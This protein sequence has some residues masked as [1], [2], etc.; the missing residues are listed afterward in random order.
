[1]EGHEAGEGFLQVAVE[2]GLLSEDAAA[3]CRRIASVLAEI[4]EGKPIDEIAVQKGYLTRKQADTVR[5]AAESGRIGAYQVLERLGAGAVGAVFR[6]RDT[7]NGTIVALKVLTEAARQHGGDAGYQR[8]LRE[9]RIATTL[10][11]PN[12]TRGFE[13][14]EIA[15]YTYLA[16]EFVPGETLEAQL[17]RVGR[18]PEKVAFQVALDVLRALEHLQQFQLIHRDVKPGNVMIPPEGAAKLCDLGLTRP[19]L[20]EAKELGVVEVPLG[21]AVYVSPEQI[22]RPDH[23]DWRAD[24]YSLGAT[25]YHAL[26]GTPPFTADSPAAVAKKHLTTPPRDPRE[27][28]LELSEGGVNVVLKMLQKDPRDRH[29]S[30]ADLADDMES[31][32]A[33]KVPVH[34]LTTAPI[35]AKVPKRTHPAHATRPRKSSAVPLVVTGVAVL[36]AGGAAWWSLAGKDTKPP[37]EPHGTAP[38]EPAPAPAGGATD[39][40]P[41]PPTPAAGRTEDDE[42]A[43]AAL[44]SALTYGAEHPDEWD[45]AR[46]RF[47][48]VAERYA[49]TASGEQAKAKIA[50]LE[51]RRGAAGD[52]EFERR[53]SRAASA[54]S[55]GQLTVAWTTYDDFPEALA[56]TAG[57]RRAAEEQTRLAAAARKRIDDA[58]GAARTAAGAGRFADAKKALDD[59]SPAALGALA[60]ELATAR[61][62]LVSEEKNAAWQRDAQRRHFGATFAEALYLAGR[63]DGA[64]AR[65]LL[66]ARRPELSLHEAELDALANDL[67]E[68]S[69]VEAAA[70]ESW[71][72]MG[73]APVQLTTAGP[74]AAKV[75]GKAAGFADT[76]LVVETGPARRVQLELRDVTAGDVIDLAMRTL[77]PRRP[78]DARA[79]LLY[80]FARTDPD[81]AAAQAESLRAAGDAAAADEGAARIEDLRTFMAEHATLLVRA[82]ETA[83]QA[84]RIDEARAKFDEAVRLAPRDAKAQFAAGTA[85]VAAGDDDR[86]QAAFE[87]AVA[88]EEAPVEAH[89]RLAQ[90]LARRNEDAAAQAEFRKFLSLADR[91]DPLRAEADGGMADVTAKLARVGAEAARKDGA[92][93]FQAKRW[94]EAEAAYARLVEFDPTDA[95]GQL[96]LGQAA[97]RQEKAFLAYRWL[98]AFLRDHA[99]DKRAGEAHKELAGLERWKG[100]RAEDREALDRARIA[101][102]EGRVDE[103]VELYRGA[104]RGSPFL[105]PARLGLARALAARAVRTGSREDHAAAVQAADDLLVLRADSLDALSVRAAS[106]LVLGD[107]ARAL[108]DAETVLKADAANVAMA[109]VAGRA[110]LA[111]D[112]LDDATQWFD[113]AFARKPS[114]EA[115]LGR[116]LVLERRRRYEHAMEALDEALESH[117]PSAALRQEIEDARRRIRPHLE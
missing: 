93:H 50:D 40:E 112:R 13:A 64:G 89:L 18:L 52:A 2:Q 30:L 23:I 113:D 59:A 33:G 26:T 107:P 43:R 37:E 5:R 55:L 88:L 72:K 97:A 117:V 105:Q 104:A 99:D 92:K 81:R 1:M 82:G 79:A 87:R 36:A 69:R 56:T 34:T 32:I 116:A 74:A 83:L 8:F 19:A 44:N 49:D 45:Q 61:E 63:G 76:R 102:G 22:Q 54:E 70:R 114:A 94:A 86:A 73:A 66:V 110:A 25:L 67:Q 65:A 28:A 75:S 53:S 17:A 48:F 51:A 16:M 62:R 14:G 35:T 29:A 47:E 12:L 95:D 68:V 98:T 109:L 7:R 111:L 96:R 21:T 58:L 101:E 42:A 3:D 39:V 9:S 90:V 15:G 4:G 41:P 80:A 108:A 78:Q 71:N 10:N 91:D 77:D 24:V 31:V 6:A 27:F 103:A 57:G 115:L 11:H 84:K 20:T 38:V 60:D 106:L 85:A 100:V 46:A